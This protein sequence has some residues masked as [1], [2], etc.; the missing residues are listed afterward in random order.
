[1]KRFAVVVAVATV[2]QKQARNRQ[3]SLFIGEWHENTDLATNVSN[4]VDKK[5]R[6]LTCI[7][8][9]FQG[10]DRN[11]EFNHK[12]NKVNKGE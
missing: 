8:A 12:G 9:D 11:S 5:R 7:L 4:L 2:A 3:R 10:R 6:L 1:V